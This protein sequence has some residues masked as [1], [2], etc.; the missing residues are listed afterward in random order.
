MGFIP[1]YG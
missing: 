1:Y